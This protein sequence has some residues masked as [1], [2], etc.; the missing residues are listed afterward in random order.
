L[1]IST[2]HS[3]IYREKSERAI[4]SGLILLELATSLTSEVQI[5]RARESTAETVPCRLETVHQH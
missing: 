1:P 5:R 4:V 2:G 3:K